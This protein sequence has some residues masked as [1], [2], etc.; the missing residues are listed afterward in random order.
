MLSSSLRPN[1]AIGELLWDLLPTGPRLGGTTTNYAVLTARLGDFSALVSCLGD[2]PFGRDAMDRLRLLAI[3]S[4]SIAD[5]QHHLDLTHIQTSVELPTGTVAVTLDHQGRP[6]YEIV[7]PVAWDAISL[8]PALLHLAANASAICFG[9]LA[10]RH[11]VS[12]E[13][14]RACIA[15]A[16]PFCVRVCDLDHFSFSYSLPVLAGTMRVRCLTR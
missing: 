6:R 10:Q 5:T 16:A 4:N 9:T 7:T 15:A 2:D 11:A 8:S 12:R 1:A 14:I 3:D 13:S